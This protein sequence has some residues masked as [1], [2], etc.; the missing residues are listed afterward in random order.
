MAI[1]RQHNTQ[2]HWLRKGLAAPNPPVHKPLLDLHVCGGSGLDD[3]EAEVCRSDVSNGSAASGRQHVSEL[4]RILG[5]RYACRG[6]GTY[7]TRL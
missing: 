3:L 2:S 1:A 7:Y 5:L 6:R 4:G